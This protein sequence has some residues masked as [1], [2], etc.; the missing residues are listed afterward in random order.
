MNKVVHDS[1]ALLALMQG[2]L[3][4]GSIN[5]VIRRSVISSVN[6]AEVYSKLTDREWLHWKLER[7]FSVCWREWNRSPR[8]KLASLDVCGKVQ[9]STDF[10]WEIVPA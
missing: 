1:S 4:A 9:G 7:R 5:A 6:L 3:G 8:N 10:R 2:E